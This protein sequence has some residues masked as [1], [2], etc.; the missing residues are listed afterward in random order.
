MD[1]ILAYHTDKFELLI[2]HISAFKFK[3]RRGEYGHFHLFKIPIKGRET[4]MWH[5]I[6]TW[7]SKQGEPAVAFVNH[8][9]DFTPS[10][11]FLLY[12]RH[13]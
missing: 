12:L 8:N 5:Q 11:L 10:I 7:Q 2:L 6:N 13:S 1:L 4:N 9:Y 3:H